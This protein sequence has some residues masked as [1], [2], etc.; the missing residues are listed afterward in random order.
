MKSSTKNVLLITLLVGII[1][2]TIAYAALSTS[3][4]ISTTTKINDTNWDIHFEN[5]TLV[6]NASGNTGTV[7]KPAKIQD[8]TTQIKELVV[9]LKKPGDFVSYTFD[10]VNNGDIAA[11]LTSIVFST[12]NCGVN[13]TECQNLEYSL[14][15]TT[16]GITPAVNNILQKKSRINATLTIK[17]K[18]N[19]PLIEEDVTANGIDIT[20][21]YTQN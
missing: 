5:L 17:Y 10:I 1:S 20:M 7:V 6:E 4:K 15:Y 21:I 2:M 13:S 12:P 9:D 11:K 3:L 18:E 16:S 14:K 19:A 8:N